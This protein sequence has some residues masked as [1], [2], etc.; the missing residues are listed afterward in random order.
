MP[1]PIHNFRQPMTQAQ[2]TMTHTAINDARE[3]RKRYL[4][5]ELIP[6]LEK[7]YYDYGSIMSTIPV[8]YHSDEEKKAF[9]N[10]LH[11]IDIE[12]KIVN[13]KKSPLLDPMLGNDKN[14]LLNDYQTRLRELPAPIQRLK[15]EVLNWQKKYSTTMEYTAWH[16]KHELRGELL[17]HRQKELSTLNA[18]TP[19]TQNHIKSATLRKLERLFTASPNDPTML[20]L[21]I[22]DGLKKFEK[23]MPAKATLEEKIQRINVH[24]QWMADIKAGLEA[25]PTSTALEKEYNDREHRLKVDFNNLLAAAERYSDKT[26]LK[27]LPDYASFLESLKKLDERINNPA[28]RSNVKLLEATSEA[29]YNHIFVWAQGKNKQVLKDP[30]TGKPKEFSDAAFEK[31]LQI[32]TQSGGTYTTKLRIVQRLFSATPLGGY[33]RYNFGSPEGKAQFL[34]YLAQAQNKED[35]AKLK[36]Q[37]A[38]SQTASVR[39]SIPPTTPTMTPG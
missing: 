4:E 28:L 17:R 29:K 22:P 7:H 14:Q 31:A 6:G 11:Y 2:R 37:E 5:A 25:D 32:H 18:K 34:Q 39:A 3:E 13:L 20:S 19:E 21:S 36:H 16:E 1:A 12:Q 38:P 33:T 10:T 27:Q 24:L 26:G 9:I 8:A 15:T 35:E 23:D 30:I